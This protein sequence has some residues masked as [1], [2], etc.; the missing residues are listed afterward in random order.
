MTRTSR[1]A[2]APS[3]PRAPVPEP[4]I[5]LRSEAGPSRHAAR[6]HLS[7]AE[8]QAAE[9]F[10][11]GKTDNPWDGAPPERAFTIRE[12]TSGKKV[13][14]KRSN[15]GPL[16]LGLSVGRA[17]NRNSRGGGSDAGER[18]GRNH[19]AQ[20]RLRE[21]DVEGAA[22]MSRLRGSTAAMRRSAC[23]FS[24]TRAMHYTAVS[25]CTGAPQLQMNTTQIRTALSNCDRMQQRLRSVPIQQS[26]AEEQNPVSAGSGTRRTRPP[27]SPGRPAA[28]SVPRLGGGAGSPPPLVLSG[29]AASLTPY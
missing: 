19:R 7:D 20:D 4:R 1:C 2:P 25:A 16:V 14:S 12:D 17:P 5:G 15:T 18:A 11:T 22:V 3:R 27:A 21:A 9:D 10:I 6:R 28:R 8:K 24:S 26:C 23:L 13:H 29:H